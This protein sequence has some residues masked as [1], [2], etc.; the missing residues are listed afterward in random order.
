MTDT[1]T[2]TVEVARDSV[3][4]LADNIRDLTGAVKAMFDGGL[5]QEAIVLLLHDHSKVGKRDIKAVLR[6]LGGLDFY[7]TD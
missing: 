6:S 2:E 4:A 7:L 3:A 1:T 5:S